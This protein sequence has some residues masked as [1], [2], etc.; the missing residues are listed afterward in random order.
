MIWIVTVLATIAAAVL[1]YP[2]S[3]T[4]WLALDMALRPQWDFDE[5]LEQPRPTR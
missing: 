2:F 1:F 4:L 5:D 3:K